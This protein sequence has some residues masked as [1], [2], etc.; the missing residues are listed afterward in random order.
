MKEFEINGFPVKMWSDSIDD[1]AWK[2]LENLVSQPFAFKHIALM[3]GV[4]QA[5]VCL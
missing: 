3:P 2:E 1:F 4:R 5:K